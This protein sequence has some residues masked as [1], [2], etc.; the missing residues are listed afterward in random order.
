MLFCGIHYPLMCKSKIQYYF[1]MERSH[2]S[3]ALG[4]VFRHTLSIESQHPPESRHESSGPRIDPTTIDTP[5]I[6]ANPIRPHF[7]NRFIIHFNY[8]RRLINKWNA[9]NAKLGHLCSDLIDQAFT[10]DMKNYITRITR[11][12]ETEWTGKNVKRLGSF[13]NSWKSLCY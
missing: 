10:G 4:S 12:N 1:G 3:W 8:S 11:L 5:R 6:N 9:S 7:K 13:T 2:N